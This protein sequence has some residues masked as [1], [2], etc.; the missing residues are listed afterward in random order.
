MGRVAQQEGCL[1]GYDA[2]KVLRTVYARLRPARFPRQSGT[3]SVVSALETLK[4]PEIEGG[5]AGKPAPS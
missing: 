3:V 1:T 2:H 5:Q 4:L